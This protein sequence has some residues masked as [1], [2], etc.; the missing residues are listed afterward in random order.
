MTTMGCFSV[1]GRPSRSATGAAAAGPAATTT[2]DA[3]LPPVTNKPPFQGPA[4]D[5][6]SNQSDKDAPNQARIRLKIL[7]GPERFLRGVTGRR[8]KAAAGGVA[9]ER[10]PEAAVA[11]EWAAARWEQ[12]ILGRRRTGRPDERRCAGSHDSHE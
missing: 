6:H 2:G 10:T 9:V 12:A 7:N 3:A 8:A 5:K 1:A 4:G 11:G